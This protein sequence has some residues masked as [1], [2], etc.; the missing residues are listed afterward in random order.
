MI[1][2]TR[3]LVLRAITL[4]DINDIYEYSKE[5]NVG[6][7]AGWKPHETMEETKQIAEQI[8]IKQ[9]GVFGIILKENNKM[10]G[11]VRNNRR[12]QKRK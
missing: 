4:D 7:N 9:E 10:I 5:P 6:P 3:R 1:I 12:S 2:E 8:F 11:S